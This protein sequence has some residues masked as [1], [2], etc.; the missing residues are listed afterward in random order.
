MYNDLYPTQK[1]KKWPF[2]KLM[3]QDSSLWM[4]S[5]NVHK[6]Q[7][8]FRE[9]FDLYIRAFIETSLYGTVYKNDLLHF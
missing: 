3:E 2:Y 8:G 5:S 1:A 9:S 4:Y 7:N 6:N